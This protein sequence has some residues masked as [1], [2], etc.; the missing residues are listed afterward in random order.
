MSHRHRGFDRFVDNNNVIS[1][2][3]INVLNGSH[4]LL[5]RAPEGVQEEQ[6]ARVEAAQRQPPLLATDTRR[7]GGY[8]WME[9]YV[10]IG[11]NC[12]AICTLQGSIQPV[13]ICI[14][15]LLRF[16]SP[17][18]S[19]QLILFN[20]TILVFY[21]KCIYFLGYNLYYF[22][23]SASL[24]FRFKYCFYSIAYYAYCTYVKLLSACKKFARISLLVMRCYIVITFMT[25]NLKY[26]LCSTLKK[27]Q[28]INL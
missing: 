27:C 21:F 25:I 6:G 17:V 24:H 1:A 2:S 22:Y 15:S 26:V 9:P 10:L 16:Y 5:S 8:D 28:M 20:S 13:V 3:R 7:H 12:K 23:F 18:F 4:T 14:S 11:P 19:S